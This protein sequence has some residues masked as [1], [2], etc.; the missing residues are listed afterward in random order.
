MHPPFDRAP[1]KAR[2][3][4]NTDVFGGGSQGHGVGRGQFGNRA[5]SR[6]K[7]IDH[8]PA[9]SVREGME[10]AIKLLGRMLN[11]LVD[12]CR[13][14][15]PAQEVTT[16]GYAR[17][18]GANSASMARSRGSE[19]SAI[20]PAR[21][22]SAST[23]LPGSGPS[24]G[25]HRAVHGRDGIVCFCKLPPA[26]GLSQIHPTLP[27]SEPAGVEPIVPQKLPNAMPLSGR[28]R[29]R[30]T[31]RIS[32]KTE[33]KRAAFKLWQYFTSHRGVVRLAVS[34]ECPDG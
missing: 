2:F 13:S 25:L 24:E 34:P 31:E 27:S 12:H 11:H 29:L 4:E 6:C 33:D 5:L 32:P 15:W 21:I 10:D 22:R 28:A 1:Q 20:R 30:R 19:R 8:G 17:P 18:E 14:V 16:K 7:L 3:F 26:N 9:G 23:K